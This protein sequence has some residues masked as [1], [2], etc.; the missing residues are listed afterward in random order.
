MMEDCLVDILWWAVSNQAADLRSSPL[1]VFLNRLALDSDCVLNVY[2][3]FYSDIL[4]Y[5]QHLSCKN[6]L[7]L[8]FKNANCKFSYRVVGSI[9]TNIHL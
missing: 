1:R 8:L 7:N 4:C 3:S 2:T 6:H 5:P 9:E